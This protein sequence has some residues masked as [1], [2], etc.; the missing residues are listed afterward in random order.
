[1]FVINVTAVND[2]PIADNDTFNVSEG[3]TLNEPAPGVLTG[4]TDAEGSGLTAVLVSGPAHASSFTLNA[5]GSFSYA[6][7]GSEGTTDSFTYRANDGGLDSNVATVTITIGAVDDAPVATDDSYGVNEGATLTIVAPGVLTNDTDPEGS[8]LTSALISGPANASSFTLNA[9][10]SFSYTHN[11]SETLTDSFTYEANDGA[12]DSNVATVTIAITGVNDPPVAVDDAGTTN[13]DTVLSV[14]AAGVLTNDTDPDAGDTKTVVAVNG[15]GASVGTPITTAKGATLTLN[16]NGSY[17]YDPIAV[18]AFQAL[19]TGET[20][21][22]TFT[23]T[24]QDTA[25]VQSTATVTITITG[26]NDAPVV[27]TSGGASA[28]TEDG[29]AV[30]VD[31]GVTVTDVDVE[32]MTQATVTIANL[33]NPGLET[34]AATTL[35]GGATANYVAPTLTISGSATLAQ[36]QTMLR[37]VTYNNTSQNPNTTAR[38]IA[39]QVNDGTVGSNVANKTVSVAAVNDG[40]AIT[41]GATILFTEGDAATVIDNTITVGDAD[42]TN[43]ESATVQITGN[44]ASPQDVLAMPVSPGIGSAFDGPSGTLTLLGSATLAQYQAALRTV[45]YFNGSSNPSPLARTVTWTV[46]DG[47]VPSNSATSTINV[48]P[49]NG[50]PVGGVDAWTTFGNT[51]LVVDQAGPATPFVADT[52]TTG[53]GVLDNDSDPD[54]DLFSVVGIAIGG[55]PCADSSRRTCAPRPAA[56]A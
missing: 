32:P 49:V 11:G 31:G 3:G 45:T 21:T 18:A 39:F 17:T 34:L 13:E 48:L 33:L 1:M 52:T 5:D 46:H 28:F 24:M 26:V 7:D 47:T 12:L 19:D 55:V 15:S 50:A 27:T 41:A 44:Y 35:L 22:D 4:D 10:G 42:D 30:V 37:A 56:A 2:A 23:Y 54:G 25:A 43:I 36:Y 14:P 8:P 20:D 16:A 40:P 6:H 53:F 38:T 9:D 29:G 51:E